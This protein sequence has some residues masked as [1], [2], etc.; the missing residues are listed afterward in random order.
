MTVAQL[1]RKQFAARCSVISNALLLVVK[2]IVCV[3]TGSVGVLAEVVNS[4]ADLVGASIVWLSVR[5]S[6]VPP[7]ASHAYG[8]GKIENLSGVLTATLILIGGV[9]AIWEAIQHLMHPAP[10]KFIGPAIVVMGVSMVVNA[11]ISRFLLNVG[12]ETDSPALIADGHH[13]QTDAIT[14]CGVLIGLT[15]VAMTGGH[16]WDSVA[17]LLVAVVILRLGYFLARDALRTLS[18]TALPMDEEQKLTDVLMSHPEVLGFHKLRTRK[19]GSH[20]HAD[21]HVQIADT[22]TFVE[23]HRLTEDLEDELRRALPNLH[24]IIHMEPFE[25]EQEHQ[26][27]FHNGGEIQRPPS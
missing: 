5:A 21:V 24:P 25:D 13:L 8:H 27:A 18:D 26:R 10:L 6:D 22:H 9:Y 17:A 12:K 20:R 11:F 16:W 7:D 4:L 14:S 2:G 19:S 15:L 1:R 23:A 3:L